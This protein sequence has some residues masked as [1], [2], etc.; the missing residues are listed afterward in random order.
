MKL[1]IFVQTGALSG[2]QFELESGALNIGRGADCAVQFEEK[3]VSTHHAT[4]QS[5]PNGFYIADQ[6]STNGTFL[7]GMR[8]E[9]SAWLKGGDIIQLGNDGPKLQVLSDSGAPPVP[10][11]TVHQAA[12]AQQPMGMGMPLPEVKD[13]T[14]LRR[15]ITNAGIYN[16]E[17]ERRPEGSK[18]EGSKLVGILVALAI[19]GIMTL[20]VMGIMISNLGFI[21]AVIG[22]I[23]AFTPAPFY[24]SLFVWL[25]RYD[26][27]P[28]WLL[29]LTWAW[30]ALLAIF[31][32]FI[33]NT[34]FGI[35]TAALIDPQTGDL[36]SAVISAPI[37]EEA[38]KGSALIL[39]LIF[40]R[41]EFDGILDGIVYAGVVGLG[42]ATVEN[43]L[44]YGNTFLQSGLGG[45][46][47]FI[48]FLRGV[49]SPF[50]HSFFTSMT[51]IGCGISRETHNKALKFIM[52]VAG[53]FGAVTLHGLWNLIASFAVGGMFFIVYFVVWVPVFL[54][55]LGVIFF[56]ARRELKVIREM[57]AIE[58]ATGLMTQQQLELVG[59]FLERTKWVMSSFS[60]RAKFKA[61]RK[62]LRASA[63]LAFC[64]WHVARASAAGGQ[65]MS[66]PQIPKFKQEVAALQRQI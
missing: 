38:T 5:D 39:L 52:P 61:R 27:E 41:R 17:R 62:F 65:T 7:N 49:L 47:L 35:M 51:G 56:M 34:A 20:L 10:G 25:D 43:V 3:V 48:G 1:R 4:I 33:V 29:A 14:L 60:D 64:Y 28:A 50:I 30:G 37:V 21:G 55:F 12:A 18:P 8:V 24:V 26:P 19:T 54:I 31:V 44:Y 22:F 42:F 13:A 66:L 57:L 16:P 32:S 23:M 45:G 40:M 2:N 36:A 59:S 46:L 11:P 58:V 53:Y 63:K 15:T 9:Q 6:G